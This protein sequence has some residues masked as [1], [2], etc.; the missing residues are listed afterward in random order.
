MQSLKQL[1]VSLP[2]VLD[3]HLVKQLQLQVQQVVFLVKTIKLNLLELLLHRHR[4]DYLAL[5]LQHLAQQ[6]LLLQH[7]VR[8]IMLLGNQQPKTNQSIYL[9]S[10]KSLLQLLVHLLVK[11]QQRQLRHLVVLDS[12]QVRNMLV[13]NPI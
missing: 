1:L 9:D 10:N 12:R 6:L 8:P 2:V 7:L 5:Q 13:N 4:V 11:L 3:F